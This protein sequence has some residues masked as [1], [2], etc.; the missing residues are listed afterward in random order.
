MPRWR[1][2]RSRAKLN[3][4]P[5]LLGNGV[6]VGVPRSR[7]QTFPLALGAS[8]GEVGRRLGKLNPLRQETPSFWNWIGPASSHAA[9]AANSF[10]ACFPNQLRRLGW[11]RCDDARRTAY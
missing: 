8:Q 3:E 9:K 1:G 6:V 2:N 5:R 11:R 10:A 4:V 7:G